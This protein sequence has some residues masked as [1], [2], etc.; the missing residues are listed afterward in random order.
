MGGRRGESPTVWC[1]S[2]PMAT[3]VLE[4]D[5]ARTPKPAVGWRRRIVAAALAMSIALGVLRIVPGVRGRFEHLPPS[6]SDAQ[7]WQLVSDLSEPGGSFISDNYVS[8]ES[9]FQRV[10]PELKARTPRHG[11]YLGVGPDQ[12]F[13]YIA[14]LEPKIAFIIDIRRKNLLL[15]LMY[16]AIVEL[17]SDRVELLSRLFSRPPPAGVDR[18]SPARALLESYRTA[19]ADERL[20]E[21]NA[22]AI[23]DH[24]VNRHGFAL[25]RSDLAGIEH[26]YRAFF[27]AGPELRYAH[28]HRWFASFAELAAETDDQGHSHGYLSSEAAFRRVKALETDNLIVPIVGDFAGRKAIRAVGRYLKAHGATVNVFYTSNVEFYLFESAAWTD[29]LANVASLP[30]DGHSVFIRAHFDGGRASGGGSRSATE[31][32]P[33]RSTIARYHEGRIHSYSDVIGQ[34]DR[35]LVGH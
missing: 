4:F 27:E 14:A 35:P 7:F 17:S 3:N 16:K 8:N 15:H 34:S 24:L 5:R 12:N 33:I 11:V 6:L 2:R 28:P 19:A 9:A 20:F 30:I 21:R 1:E 25:S 26:V 32:D 23:T 18:D 22:R 31:L 29:F 13:T 10:I